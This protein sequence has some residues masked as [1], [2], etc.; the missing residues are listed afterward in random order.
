MNIYEEN[1]A[2]HNLCLR[3]LALDEGGRWGSCHKMV[4]VIAYKKGGS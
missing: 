3:K 1:Q 2:K 4:M